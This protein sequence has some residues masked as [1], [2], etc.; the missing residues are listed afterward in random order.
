[1]VAL[2]R[3]FSALGILGALADSSLGK[4]M[5]GDGLII[6]FGILMVVVGALILTRSRP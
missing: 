5:D 6:L 4:A 3:G 2:R 1:M